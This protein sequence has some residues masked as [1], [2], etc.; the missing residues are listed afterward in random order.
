MSARAGWRGGG[1]THARPVLRLLPLPGGAD[2]AGPRP[3]VAPPHRP[4][5]ARPALL[6]PR[7]PGVRQRGTTSRVR[8]PSSSWGSCSDGRERRHG[9]LGRLPGGGGGDRAALRPGVPEAS[10]RRPRPQGG[11]G[12]AGDRPAPGPVPLRGPRP[13]YRLRDLR[14]R[15]P[16]GGRPRDRGRYGHGGERAALRRARPL[17]AGLSGGGDPGRPG[18]PRVPEGR[19]PPGRVAPDDRRGPVHRRASWV[20]SP[21]SR[22][23]S[24]RPARRWTAWPAWPRPP[25]V[26]AGTRRSTSWS[27]APGRRVSPPPPSPASGAS[28]TSCSSSRPI[29]GGRSSTTRGASSS[30][31]RPVELPFYGLLREAEYPKEQL[32]EILEELRRRAS[33]D[34]RFGEKVEGVERD[35]PS[36]GCAPPRG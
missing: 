31:C 35:G 28:P 22:T 5:R 17:R 21:W 6:R 26:P 33:L 25:A 14:R 3:A 15:L 13:L 2:A 12:A 32:L 29:S 11:G 36:S 19:P 7:R 9:A 10:S 34:I 24:P 27:S 8:G 16:R 1:G 23:P 30:C 20:G 18:G 4:G